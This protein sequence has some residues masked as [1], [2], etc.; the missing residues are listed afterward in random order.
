MFGDSMRK[1]KNKCVPF[2]GGAFNVFFNTNGGEEITNMH[3]GIACS[4]DS[5]LDLPTPK[6][7]G[8]KFEGWYYDKEFREK[9]E[10]RNS[11][12]IKAELEYDKKGCPV[13]YKDRELFA[14]WKD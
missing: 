3:V 9:V 2:C 13:G 8:Y 4:P 12:D 11:I 6:K 14:K 1:S 5:Y 7:E 10:S